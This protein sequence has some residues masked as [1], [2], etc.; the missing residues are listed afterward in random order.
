MSRSVAQTE[1]CRFPSAPRYHPHVL[2][3]HEA[4]PTVRWVIVP[5]RLQT[6]LFAMA[7]FHTREYNKRS[8]GC[9]EGRAIHLC[10]EWTGLSG[11]FTVKERARYGR[12]FQIC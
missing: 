11:S 3:V 7:S 4:R 5:H 12:S 2:V 6:N 10:H 1:V 8:N 9:Q